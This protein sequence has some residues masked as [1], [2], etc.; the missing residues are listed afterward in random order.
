ML[1]ELI[2]KSFTTPEYL[3]LSKLQFIIFQK[4][5]SA[6]YASCIFSYAFFNCLT[7]LF[8]KLA[9]SLSP[10]DLSTAVGSAIM[11]LINLFISPA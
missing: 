3:F 1:E 2:P 5:S 10:K 9:G 11:S 7:D 6:T 8:F 4:S